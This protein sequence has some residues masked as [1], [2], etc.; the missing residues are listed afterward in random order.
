MQPYFSN[1]HARRDFKVTLIENNEVLL[2]NEEVAKEI[3]QYFR[4]ITD[5]L[6]LYE[7]P[8]ENFCE[9][10][11]DI[12]NIG[13]KCKIHPRIIKIKERYK[14]K[15]NFSFG[16]ATTEKIK[17]TIRDPFRNKAARGEIPVNILKKYKFYFDELTVCINRSLIYGKLPSA[18][19][20]ANVEPVHEKNDPIDK[21][22][23]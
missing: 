8:Y 17:A 20:N 12:D 9:G 16:L 2:K 3:N 6:D 5:S 4:H 23:F 15:G 14:F 1:K 10:L 7:L 11:D 18:F 21:T 13:R 22:N 19:K